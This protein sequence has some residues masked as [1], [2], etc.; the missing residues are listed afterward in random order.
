MQHSSWRLHIIA[1]RPPPQ[2][3]FGFLETG[4]DGPALPSPLP[5]AEGP[6]AL[7]PPPRLLLAIPAVPAQAS[8]VDVQSGRSA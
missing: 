1:F 7:P 8:C 4:E 5:R 6:S 3:I 2:P